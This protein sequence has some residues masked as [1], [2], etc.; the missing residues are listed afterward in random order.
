[1]KLSYM[2]FDMKKISLKQFDPSYWEI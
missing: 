2:P 1:M